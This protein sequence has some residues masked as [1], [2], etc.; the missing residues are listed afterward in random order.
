MPTSEAFAT[1]FYEDERL[2][3]RLLSAMRLPD[4]TTITST[5]DTTTTTTATTATTTTNDDDDDDDALEAAF[6]ATAP[7]REANSAGASTN[8]CEI[9]ARLIDT[10]FAVDG[11]PTRDHAL[12]NAAAVCELMTFCLVNHKTRMKNFMLH[13]PVMDSVASLCKPNGPTHLIL[14]ASNSFC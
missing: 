6:A 9:D 1:V 3:A 12:S 14:S 13:H 11:A 2:A 7:K 8:S 10:P 4:T 5:N